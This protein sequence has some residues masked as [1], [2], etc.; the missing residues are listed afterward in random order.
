MTEAERLAKEL[1]AEQSL[2]HAQWQT[3]E[4]FH[5]AAAEL[6]RLHEENANLREA[7]TAALRWMEGYPNN[8]RGD[9][10]EQLREALGET[11]GSDRM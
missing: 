3:N 11:N 2:K 9:V 5:P 1:D 8:C 7:V 4:R 10:E 6:R